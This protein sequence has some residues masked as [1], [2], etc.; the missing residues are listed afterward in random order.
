MIDLADVRP[1]GLEPARLDYDDVVARL[2]ASAASWVPRHFPNGRKVAGEWRLAN[3]QGDPPRKQGSCVITLTGEHAGDWHDFD[4]GAGGGPLSG[5]GHA[6]GLTGRALLEHAAETVGRTPT[7]PARRAPPPAA[8][9]PD[10]AREIAHILAGAQPLAGTHAEIY[11]QSRGLQASAT[12]DLLFHPDLVHRPTRTGFPGM[13]G[14]V[15]DR[16][17]AAHGIHRTYLRPDGTAKADVSPAR[18][19]L[20][21]IVGCAVRL[22]P[23]GEDGYLGIAEGIETAL[24]VMTA[25][26][27][28]PVWAALSASHMEQIELPPE[29]RHVILLADHDASGAGLRAAEAA[30]RRLVLDGRSVGIALPPEEGQDF[31][32]VLMRDGPAAVAA[33]VRAAAR[34]S[35]E[36]AAAPEIG[37]HRP[38]GFVP[39][40][41]SLPVLRADAGDL[42][43]AT[44][45]AWDVIR[46]SNR[47]PW[48]FRLGGHPTWVVPDD[49]G[50]PVAVTV[51]DEQLRHMLAGIADWRKANRSDELVP[52]PPPTG[53]V[54]SL[55]ATPDPGLPVL[56]GIVTTPVF[57]RTGTLLTEPGYHPDARLLYRP[58]PGFRLPP[59]PE[60]PSAAEIAAARSLLL[61]DLLGDFPFIG[62]AERAHV[63]SLLLLGFMRAMIPG[64]TPLHLIEKP[65]PGTGAGLMIDVIST[66]VIGSRAAVMTESRDD[67]EWRKRLTAKLRQIPAML[68]IDNLRS[69]LDSSALAAALTA[70]FWEDRI[71]GV[72]EMARVPIRCVWIATG[73]NPSFSNEMARRLVR[74]RLDARLHEPWRREGFRHPNLM[75][76]VAA[77]HGRLVAACLTLGRAWLAAGRPRGARTLGSFEAWAGT[78][79]GILEV[80]GVE[81]FLGNLDELMATS[82]AEGVAWRAFVGAWWDRFGTAEVGTADLFEVAIVSEPPLPLGSG[83]EHSRRIRLGK[84]LGRM[85]DRMFK[86]DGRSV[87]LEAT[88]TLQGVNR[89]QLT[90][91]PGSVGGRVDVVGVGG[92]ANPNT[93][94]GNTLEGQENLTPR[95]CG[96]CFDRPSAHTGARAR[97]EQDPEKHPQHP[98]HPPKPGNPRVSDSGCS[99]GCYAEHPM[100][101]D[102]PA[103]LQEVL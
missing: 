40:T 50:R 10:H 54:K 64:P 51:G 1:L 37:L 4:T 58:L 84:A 20:G 17:G 52:A 45:R 43:Y 19:T 91:D 5:L 70:P 56:G 26:P 99:G 74:I 16:D 39:R 46:A 47:E 57:G 28:L 14:Q 88:G 48:L 34:Q 42:A 21:R 76:W 71:L 96:G 32:D 102:P 44:N 55:L 90:I 38:V 6:T 82:D 13:V 29:A 83:G 23:I 101:S 92:S 27:G 62:A 75:E 24:A 33:I 85:R 69:P 93:H 98:Q 63:L 60:R 18:M 7:P 2:R 68:L 66:I 87:R 35:T 8:P 103:W 79:G 61:D 25:C 41:G 53:L 31:N 49:D 97:A 67:E 73:N 95:G 3:I 22:A 9:A 78:I 77:N 81:G 12:A 94:G 59:I 100:I 30:R 11:L 36:E 65:A 72:S 89:W 15:R 80:A 86:L